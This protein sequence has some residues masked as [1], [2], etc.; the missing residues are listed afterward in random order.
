M[1]INPQMFQKNTM[2]VIKIKQKTKRTLST[3]APFNL[4]EILLTIAN[5]VFSTLS[6]TLPVI[7]GQENK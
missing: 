4:C 6:H 3:L 1:N 7:S 2:L 5:T